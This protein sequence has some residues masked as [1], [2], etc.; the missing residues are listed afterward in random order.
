[1]TT[2]SEANQSRLALKMELSKYSWY[3][4]A[5][6]VS[7]TDGFAVII[8]VSRIDDTV[9]RTVPVVRNGVDIKTET[10]NRKRKGL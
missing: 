2:F 10:A 5:V 9:K 6:V 4:G 8:Q 1:M 7:T 3:D